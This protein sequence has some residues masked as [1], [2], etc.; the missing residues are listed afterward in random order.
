VV[1]LA[2]Q[3]VRPAKIAAREN[4]PAMLVRA[5]AGSTAAPQNGHD[6]SLTL[7]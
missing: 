4:R 1:E 2:A 3:L 5:D 7:T 6:G